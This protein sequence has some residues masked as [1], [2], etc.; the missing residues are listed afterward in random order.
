MKLRQSSMMKLTEQI[1]G[2]IM[3]AVLFQEMKR[4]EHG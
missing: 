1:Y 3:K 4:Q 2:I